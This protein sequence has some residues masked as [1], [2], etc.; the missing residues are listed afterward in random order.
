M[1]LLSDLIDAFA[2]TEGPPP[3]RLGAFLRWA[4]AGAFPVIGGMLVISVATGA[5]EVGAAWLVGWLI[6]HA[7]SLG[8]EGLFAELWPVMLAVAGFFLVLRPAVMGLGAAVTALGLQPNLY[9]LVLSRLNRH[10]LGQSLSYFDDDFAGRISQ[11]AQQSARAVTEVV[12]ETVNTFGFAV[13][14]VV[15]AGILM[16]AVNWWLAAIV[17]LWIGA[18]VALV[19]HYLPRVRARSKDRAA[20][21]AVVTGQIVD[22]ISNIATVKLFAHGDFEDRAALNALAGYRDRT[23][24]FG[25]VAA[26]FRFWL[27]LLAG[28]LPVALLGGALWFWSQGLATA[29]EIATAGLISTR[30]AQMS[31]WVSMTAMGIFAN[32][33]EIEDGIRTLS[34]RHRVIDAAHARAPDAV[35]GAVAFE[36]VR[37]GY[38]R[39]EAALDGLDLAIAPGERVALV[40]RSGAGKTTAVSL[41]LRLYDVEG[42]RITLD[43]TD[44]RDLTQDGLRA[45][46][47][48]VRQETAM[49]NRSA[50]ENIRYGRPQASDA[51][52][53]AAAER[54]HAHEFILGLR[55]FKGRTGYGAHLGERG[56]KLSGGQRQRIA[57]A[58]VILK[59]APVLV[60]D[61]ATSALDSEVEAAIQDT[62]ETVMRGKTVLAIAHRLSTIAR[63]D[64]IVVLDAGRIVEEGSHATLLARGGLYA[65]FWNR[66]SGGFI[67]LAAE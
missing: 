42:G 58:R 1:R 28:T 30:L 3:E 37:F 61:E 32:I 15:G 33:G 21:R 45:Q 16:A 46:I 65:R 52:V 38:G 62:L 34:P 35:R 6:D 40:G 22:T 60:L 66:Q 9:P 19:R 67:N 31:G 4:L 53:M 10:V 11:K 44:I 27:M 57:L 23:I 12:T 17:A 48:M 56:V 41:L 14:A 64:R 24:R 13:A 51:E 59:N 20:A 47:G 2:R 7:Q 49:F 18:Y 29:G 36:R 39:R 50:M 55:D 8:P 54:A 5:T 43:G 26:A 25:S 63:M